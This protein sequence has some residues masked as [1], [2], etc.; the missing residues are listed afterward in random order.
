MKIAIITA[1][2][3]S[4]VTLN[5]YGFHLVK[6]FL[7]R[8][9]ISEVVVLS[10]ITASEFIVPEGWDTSRLT[11]EKCWSFN[12]WTNP[13]TIV[14]ALK[15]HRPNDALFNLQ[16]MKFGDSKIAAALGLTTPWLSRLF[17]FPT[18][19]L[20]HNI[21]ETV[22]LDKA[23][24][25]GNKIFQRIYR[26][27]GTLLTRV[28]LKSNAVALTMEDYVRI[29]KDKYKATNV[30]LIPHGT[31]DL[32]ANPSFESREPY[33]I[34]TFGK[35]G[36]YKKVELLIEAF[37]GLQEELSERVELIIAGSDNPNT[38]GYLENAKK[39]YANV[40]NV[41]FTGYV[42]EEDVPVLFSEAAMVVFPYTSTTGSS[43]VL[44]QAGSYGKAVVMPYIDDL[45]K[46]VTDEGFQG[47]F[48]NSN[49]VGS[50]KA[51]LKEL[52]LNASKRH[53]M[54]QTNYKA[55]SGHPM[56]E[57]ADRYVQLFYSMKDTK[58][59]LA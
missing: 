36:T 54:G 47:E 43:G 4:E 16:F 56:S 57:I 59:S 1:L 50:L 52:V 40:Q 29:L 20:L 12:S 2:P 26:A 28:V 58:L 18:T 46:L 34:L 11:I 17:G 38:P 5:E 3:P 45:A 42:K 8:E 49:D 35:F 55:A 53:D 13:L 6:S 25:T 10:D 27:I 39:T 48:F 22:D 9:D 19:T 14:K 31:F 51:A 7:E 30:H 21:L 32:P 41:S 15:K 24:F 33:K 37:E 44:H 23:G